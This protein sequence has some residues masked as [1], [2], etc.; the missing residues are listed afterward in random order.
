MNAVAAMLLTKESKLM[1]RRQRRTISRRRLTERDD[2]ER[3]RSFLFLESSL[4]KFTRLL[5]RASL[6]A[7]EED[8]AALSPHSRFT[9]SSL[10]PKPS[11]D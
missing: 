11:C 9:L 5:S 6:A 10:R 8:K 7:N 2:N 4:A 3:M 1:S